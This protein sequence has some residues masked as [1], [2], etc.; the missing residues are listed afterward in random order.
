VW[1][2]GPTKLYETCNLGWR[3]DAFERLGGFEG[4]RPSSPRGTRAHFGEDAQLGWRLVSSGGQTIYRADALVHHRVHAGSF[5]EWLRERRRL[6]LFPALVRRSPGMPDAL[7]LKVFLSWDTAVFDLALAGGAAA[8]VTRRPWLA[9]LAMP[10]LYRRWQQAG[11]R[12]GRA[13]LVRLAQL[14]IGDAVG[15]AALVAGSLKAG[16]PVF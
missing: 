14:G 1:I 4:G 5:R 9:A 12:P 6:S 11:N 2:T 13:R 10:W 7:R 3:R 16:R 15:L 8:L